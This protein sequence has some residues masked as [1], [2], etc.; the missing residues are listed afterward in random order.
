MRKLFQTAGVVFAL[1][2]NGALAQDFGADFKAFEAGDYETASKE[3]RPLADQGDVYAQFLL[4]AMYNE[5]K[6]VP[7]DD[8]E[9]V[10]WYGLAADQNHAAAQL[11][12]GIM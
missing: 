2:A 5:G 11:N 1:L 3:W 12:L 4:G 9:A 10:R 7:V 6:G 8:V